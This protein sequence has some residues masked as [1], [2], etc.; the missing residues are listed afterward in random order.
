LS[1]LKVYQR[2]QKGKELGSAMEKREPAIQNVGA[3][4]TPEKPPPLSAVG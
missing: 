4:V 1:T 2:K 3:P